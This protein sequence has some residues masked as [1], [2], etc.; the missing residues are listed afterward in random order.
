M[1][2]VA[3]H[4]GFFFFSSSWSDERFNKG[5]VGTVFMLFSFLLS[6]FTCICGGRVRWGLLSELHINIYDYK[7]QV[8]ALLSH[9]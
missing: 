5:N 7:E 9:A 8:P 4:C 6:F 1:P 3:K 2:E